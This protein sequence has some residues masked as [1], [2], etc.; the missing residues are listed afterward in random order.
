ML[1]LQLLCMNP[2][3]CTLTRCDDVFVSDVQM[4]DAMSASAN[5]YPDTVALTDGQIN[6]R[7]VDPEHTISSLTLAA[8]KVAQ[9]HAP[10]TVRCSLAGNSTAAVNACMRNVLLDSLTDQRYRCALRCLL[11]P[12]SE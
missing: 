10:D 5:V 3:S 2:D 8:D 12:L 11:P 1:H 4:R 9:E 7:L 6:M